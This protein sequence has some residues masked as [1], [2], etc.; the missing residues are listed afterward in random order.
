MVKISANQLNKL[1]KLVDKGSDVNDLIT[2]ICDSGQCPIPINKCFYY[3]SGEQ[4]VLCPIL[5]EV[6]KRLKSD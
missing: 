2:L 5:I 3:Y 4:A 1:V 6:C